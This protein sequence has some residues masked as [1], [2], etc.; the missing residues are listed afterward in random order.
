MYVSYFSQKLSYHNSYTFI[1]LLTFGLTSIKVRD[2]VHIDPSFLWVLLVL[3]LIV[4]AILMT[5]AKRIMWKL[6]REGYTGH[7]Q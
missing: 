6:L 7:N 2:C 5:I 4:T 1:S 3:M